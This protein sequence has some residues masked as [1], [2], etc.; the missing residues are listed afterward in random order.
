MSLDS[1]N[2]DSVSSVSEIT[3]SESPDVVKPD[4]TLLEKLNS[5]FLC[6]EEPQKQ[7][8][9]MKHKHQKAAIFI[10]LCEAISTKNFQFPETPHPLKT[11]NI[12]DSL[13]KAYDK[14]SK[15]SEQVK[16]LTLVPE[17]E[18][19]VD[20]VKFFDSNKKM[21]VKSKDMIKTAGVY[22]DIERKTRKI[23]Q[24]ETIDL[25]SKFYLSDA[26]SRVMPG[27]NDFVPIRG[28]DGQRKHETK[29]LLLGIIY[30]SNNK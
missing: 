29:R 8:K 21:V 5:I 30:F 28:A 24:N 20:I 1:D 3:E 19:S 14:T 27:K 26:I 10:K 25:V 23:I 7:F 16:I 11:C 6:I 9:E 13:K 17:N 2:T 15:Y 18:K 22:S 4:K 12:A